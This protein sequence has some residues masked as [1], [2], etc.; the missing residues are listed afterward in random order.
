VEVAAEHA[1]GEGAGA[2]VGVEERLL[3]DRVELKA[4]HVAPGHP[5]T[6][7]LVVAHL[8]DAALA[9]RDDA[10]MPARHAAEPSGG[11]GLPERPLPGTRV[12]QLREGRTAD[13]HGPLRVERTATGEPRAIG[14]QP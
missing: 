6:A 14:P 3:L 1:E 2:R 10:S 11:E 13:S 5:E 4:R 8:A 12:D 7:I 9:G